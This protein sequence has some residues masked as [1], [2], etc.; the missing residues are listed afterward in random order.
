MV[1]TTH[2]PGDKT[3]PSVTLAIPPMDLVYRVANIQSFVRAPRLREFLLYIAEH[4]ISGNHD[5]ISEYQIGVEV[6]KRNGSY[7]TGEDNIV[8]SYARTLRKRLEEYFSGEGAGEP[9]VLSI[10]RGAYILQFDARERF[11][12]TEPTGS[13]LP[14]AAAKIVEERMPAL[15]VL[16]RRWSPVGLGLGILFLITL[17][18]YVSYRVGSARASAPGRST[19]AVHRFWE[20]FLKGR[21]T[22]LVPGDTGLTVVLGL[23]Q[24]DVTPQQYVTSDHLKTLAVKFPQLERWDRPIAHRYCDFVDVLA[25]N[26]LRELPEMKLI[27]S[28]IRYARDARADE[29]EEANAILLGGWNANP[30]VKLYDKDLAFQLRFMPVE[31]TFRVLNR[32]ARPGEP[33]EYPYTSP[34]GP[35]SYSYGLVS[36]MP[37]LSHHGNVLLLEGTTNSGLE[38]AAQYFLTESLA[39]LTVDKIVDRHGNLIPFELLVRT[40]GIGGT[41]GKIELVGFRTHPEMADITS[42]AVVATP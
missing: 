37:S 26:Q 34:Q 21:P 33:S 29:L 38:S 15:P 35:V 42:V 20:A 22:L 31:R 7:S 9:V 23:I 19:P 41:V 24:Q 32:D 17:A 39:S 6:F 14:V 3:A 25:I 27:H 40:A 30:W 2:V 8:R 11:I 36:F 18:S 28:A 10:P 13:D 12:E 1:S 16:G 5:L 4:S